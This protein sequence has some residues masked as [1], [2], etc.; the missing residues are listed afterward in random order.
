MN[1]FGE[2]PSLFVW[3]IGHEPGKEFPENWR[4][5]IEDALRGAGFDWEWE[6]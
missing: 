2:T 6:S 3:P 5:L 4:K 1:E